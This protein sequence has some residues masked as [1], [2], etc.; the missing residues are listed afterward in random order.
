MGG[1]PPVLGPL[2]RILGPRVPPRA[3]GWLDEVLVRAGVAPDRD[4]L[5]EA[6]ATAARRLGRAP[7]ELGAGERAVLS[8]AGITWPVDTWGVDGLGRVVLLL[9][10]AAW[11]AGEFGAL[12]EGCY[13]QG[14]TRERQAVLRAL[15]LLPDPERFLPLATDACRSSVQPVFE[16]I[17]CENPYPARHFPE[18]AFNHMVLKAL[19]LG[20]GLE[21]ILGWTERWTPELRRMAADYASERRAAGRSVPGDVSRL[22]G[23]AG[24]VT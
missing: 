21:R 11:P 13:R 7:L 5:Q 1:A 20:I 4:S 14:D 23:E 9:A 16:A 17:A 3:S 12:V 10:A 6:Y 15:P 8:G 24:G 19:F 18:H 2:R 22:A